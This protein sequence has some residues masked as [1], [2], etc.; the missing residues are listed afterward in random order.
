VTKEKS[1]KRRVRERMSKTGESYTTARSHVAQKRDRVQSAR[2]RLAATADRPSDDKITEMTGRSWDAWFSILDRWG[3]RDRKHGETVRFLMDEHDVPGWWAQTITI[4]YQ[5]ASGLRLKHQQ[6]EGF[7]IYASKTI[8]VPIDLLFTA[9]VDPA[10]R[11]QWLTDGTM[12]LRTSQKNYT[13][14]FDWDDGSTRV[15]VSF[16]EK[17]SAKA[18]VSVAHERLPD[19]DEAERAKAFWRQ[20]LADLKSLLESSGRGA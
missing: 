11:K 9:F 3:G 2:T 14:R 5:R 16:V 18:T 10:M 17:D 1:L 20:R 8:A 6:A 4:Y 12:S 15:N 19:P 7:T 13:A